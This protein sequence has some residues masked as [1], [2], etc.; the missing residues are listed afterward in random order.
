MKALNSYSLLSLASA[1]LLILAVFPMSYGYYQFL[2]VFIFSVSI[3]LFSKSSKVGLERIFL[4]IVGVLFN[5]VFKVGLMRDIWI[6]LDIFAGISFLGLTIASI[7]KKIN[8]DNCNW[9]S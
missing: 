9:N 7:K 6:I 1:I 2:R 3:F 8:R 5:P 4:I